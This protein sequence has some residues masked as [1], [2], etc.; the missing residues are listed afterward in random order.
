MCR[1]LDRSFLLA[2]L[3]AGFA[4]LA[5]GAAGKATPRPVAGDG[6]EETPAARDVPLP[7]SRSERNG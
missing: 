5:P 1:Q 3:L 6:V 2:I 4:M 7:G